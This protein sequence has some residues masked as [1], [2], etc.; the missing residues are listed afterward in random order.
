MYSHGILYT[1][2]VFGD[3]AMTQVFHLIIPSLI[4]IVFIYL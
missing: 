1:L 3:D 4:T 2:S